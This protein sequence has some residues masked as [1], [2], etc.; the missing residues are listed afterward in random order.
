LG[1]IIPDGIQVTI[2]LQ[3]KTQILFTEN[4]MATFILE[5]ANDTDTNVT[6]TTLGLTKTSKIGSL[7]KE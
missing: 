1:Q 3:G 7:E 6:I 2:G 5:D 4:G